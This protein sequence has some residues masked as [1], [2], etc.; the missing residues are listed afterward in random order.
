MVSTRIY[1]SKTR[2][3]RCY[4]IIWKG[5][6]CR[7]LSI[8]VASSRG[9]PN[10]SMSKFKSNCR[11]SICVAEK[12]STESRTSVDVVTPFALPNTPPSSIP[13]VMS[14]L[15]YRSRTF[16][17]TPLSR[18]EVAF[19][20][21]KFVRISESARSITLASRLPRFALITL[22]SIEISIVTLF[23]SSSE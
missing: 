3:E 15:I 14:A 12:E 6:F 5:W 23:L 16:E 21:R 2:Y 9:V 8:A 20:L 17:S 10:S 7:V 4:A 13:A 1:Y 19:S 22:M 11:L 18:V